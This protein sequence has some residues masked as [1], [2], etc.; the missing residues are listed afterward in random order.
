MMDILL[1]ADTALFLWLNGARSPLLDE[2]MWLLSGPLPWVSGGLLCFGYL[3]ARFRKRA[4]LILL[5]AVLVVS[6]ADLLAATVFKETVMRLRPSH[7]PSIQHLVH[8]LHDY[9]G[10]KY[11][12]VSNHA[13]NSFGL[14][15]YMSSCVGRWW[16]AAAAI[17]WALA[18]SYSRIYLGVHFP[19]DIIG[20]ALLGIACAAGGYFGVRA[21]QTRLSRDV[22]GETH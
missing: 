3:V 7:D 6:I 20:G 9:R 14:S 13:A 11:G 12:F 1:T 21:L 15:V 17:V 4:L 22:M 10:G 16:F 8:I 19:G 18:I 2:A 5:G